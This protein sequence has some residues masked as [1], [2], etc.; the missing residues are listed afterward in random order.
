MIIIQ[1]LIPKYVDTPGVWGVVLL[2]I[3]VVE[4]CIS[5]DQL[6]DNV[7]CTSPS[8][9]LHFNL[10][11]QLLEPW[12]AGMHHIVVIL[13][14]YILFQQLSLRIKISHVFIQ[15]NL[16]QIILSYPKSKTAKNT[17]RCILQVSL[18]LFSINTQLK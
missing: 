12:T 6:Y 10:C 16:L 1:N 11:S 3:F 5:V 4:V 14:N 7:S 13:N 9:K 2:V 18:L 17:F 8:M 15:N